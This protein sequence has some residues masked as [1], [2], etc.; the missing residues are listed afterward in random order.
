MF[1][2]RSMETKRSLYQAIVH[3]LGRLGVPPADIKITLV[4]VP[5]EN[6]GIRGGHPAS[7]VDLG[8][9]IKV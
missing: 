3:N 2:G 9:E 4:E 6:W 5:P 1:A 7:E 8:F